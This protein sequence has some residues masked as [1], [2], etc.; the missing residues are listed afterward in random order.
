MPLIEEFLPSQDQ[1][2]THVLHLLYYG[3]LVVDGGVLDGSPS[4]ADLTAPKHEKSS[5]ETGNTQ[6]R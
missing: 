4:P 5:P 6:K 2:P 3:R 1:E